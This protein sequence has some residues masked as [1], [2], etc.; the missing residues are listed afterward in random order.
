MVQVKLSKFTSHYFKVSV[1]RGRM[2]NGDIIPNEDD[3]D[4]SSDNH[5]NDDQQ[6]T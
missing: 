4:V 5:N 3:E 6:R 2:N 1:N